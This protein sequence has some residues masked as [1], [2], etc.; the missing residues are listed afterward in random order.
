MDGLVLGRLEA[1]SLR[2][3]KLALRENSVMV[4]EIVRD[5]LLDGSSAQFNYQWLKRERVMR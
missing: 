2:V 4:I 5:G 3:V 1:S